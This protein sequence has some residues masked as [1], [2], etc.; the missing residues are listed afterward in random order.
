LLTKP[1]LSQRLT[2]HRDR[3]RRCRHYPKRGAGHRLDPLGV[4]VMPIQL[5]DERPYL[6]QAPAPL[7]RL[8]HRAAPTRHGPKPPRNPLESPLHQRHQ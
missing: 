2:D 1:R 7:I 5:A 4:Q 3:E 8:A 6:A